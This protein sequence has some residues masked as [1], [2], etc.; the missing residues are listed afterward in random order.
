MK[1]RRAN[2]NVIILLIVTFLGFIAAGCSIDSPQPAEIGEQVKALGDELAPN[3]ELSPRE[4]VKIQIEA[5]QYNNDQDK[6]IEVTFRFASPSNK[7]VT[8][9]LARFRRMIKGSAYSSMLNHKIAEYGPLELSGDMAS[10][11]VTIIEPNG[12]ASIYIFELSKQTEAPCIGCW[13]TDSVTIIP[14][15]RQEIQGA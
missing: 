2:V 14:T 4:V 9:P 10:Q 6:G 3:P 11:Q 5:L 12:K 15:R 1:K 7:R 13:M 8:G